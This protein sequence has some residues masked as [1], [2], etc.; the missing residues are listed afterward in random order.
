[1][2]LR[3]N[4]L[5]AAATTAVAAEAAI[6]HKVNSWVVDKHQA[7]LWVDPTW[8]Q[9]AWCVARALLLCSLSSLN[10]LVICCA[11]LCDILMLQQGPGMGMGGPGMGGPG[12]GGPGMGGPGMGGPGMG[13]PG[14]G[15][16]MGGPGMGGP[17]MGGP[18]MGGP[19]M[20]GPGMGG[21]G[22]GMRGGMRGGMQGGPGGPPGGPPGGGQFGG[23]DVEM[24]EKIGSGIGN[25]VSANVLRLRRA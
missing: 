23:P 20:G 10:S 22:M 9:A 5:A 15:G 11:P 19:G 16:S 21:P 18:G 14:M 6:H 24:V 12:M 3:A 7:D 17:G 8:A 13:G 1:M 2:I 4:F 25:R